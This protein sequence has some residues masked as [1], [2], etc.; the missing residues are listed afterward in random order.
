MD[1]RTERLLA[2]RYQYSRAI[3]RSVK[4]LVDPYVDERKQL[5]YHQVVLSVWA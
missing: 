4:D 2:W 1:E 5:E 3:D